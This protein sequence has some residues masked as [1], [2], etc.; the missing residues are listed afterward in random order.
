LGERKIVLRW[1]VRPKKV[2][3]GGVV[4]TKQKKSGVGS[5]EAS[6]RFSNIA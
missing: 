1:E 6:Y 5:G 3:L 2:R 4:I